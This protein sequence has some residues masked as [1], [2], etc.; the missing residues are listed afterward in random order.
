MEKSLKNKY[1]ILVDEEPDESGT[2]IIEVLDERYA[3]VRYTYG[4][5][6]NPE[7]EGDG[8]RLSFEY[9]IVEMPESVDVKQGIE[10]FET[11]LG[12]ILVHI[13]ISQEG[14]TDTNDDI[15]GDHQ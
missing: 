14:T 4:K 2:T 1:K 10:E 15:N 7:P 11:L 12:D 13:I 9:D 3:G 6:M 8:I 5:V